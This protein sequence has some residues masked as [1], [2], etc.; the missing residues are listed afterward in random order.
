MSTP[1]NNRI[2]RHKVTPK[3]KHTCENGMYKLEEVQVTL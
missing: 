1:E 2:D 3:V